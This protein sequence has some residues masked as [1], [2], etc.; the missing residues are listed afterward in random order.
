MIGKVLKAVAILSACYICSPTLFKGLTYLPI[1]HQLIDTLLSGELQLVSDLSVE[2]DRIAHPIVQEFQIELHQQ[3]RW[4]AVN[5]YRKY[6][7]HNCRLLDY[8][9]KEQKAGMKKLS[10][11]MDQVALLFA[12]DQRVHTVVRASRFNTMW[13]RRLYIKNSTSILPSVNQHLQAVSVDRKQAWIMISEVESETVHADLLS[14]R[15]MATWIQRED[16]IPYRSHHEKL[17]SFL[18]ELTVLLGSV[19]VFSLFQ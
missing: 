6:G 13:W 10:T 1:I 4:A 5:S 8:A 18:T 19:K 16:P 12:F 14:S 7:E 9:G 17:V 15:T 2:F 11:E 3:M